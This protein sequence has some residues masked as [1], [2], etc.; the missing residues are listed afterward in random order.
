MLNTHEKGKKRKK[1]GGGKANF[2][3]K[4]GVLRRYIQRLGPKLPLS[5]HSKVCKTSFT[6]RQLAAW[7]FYL[8][9]TWSFDEC[10][11]N[12]KNPFEMSENMC[13]S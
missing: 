1:G 7:N 9:E 12:N 13:Q 4:E 8:G 11:R 2:Y 10:W 6:V 5:F 3:L